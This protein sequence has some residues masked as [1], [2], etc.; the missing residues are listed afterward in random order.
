VPTHRDLYDDP[1]DRSSQ[2]D[3]PVGIEKLL[4]FEGRINRATFWT[5]WLV[6]T[7][8]VAAAAAGTRFL[9]P[10]AGGLA[11]LATVIGGLLIAGFAL[12]CVV[13]SLANEVKRYH[14]MDLSGWWV[15]LNLV[16]GLGALVIFVLGLWPG[17][18]GA[19]RFGEAP[20]K[21]RLNPEA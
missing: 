19:N 2:P 20:L 1:L 12:A 6:L 16:P 3:E 10:D 21:I 4:S 18:K 8:G 14:D 5:T 11:A 17:T 13:M 15:L 7:C 9:N